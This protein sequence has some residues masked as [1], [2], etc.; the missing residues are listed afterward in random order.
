MFLKTGISIVNPYSSYHCFY[1]GTRFCETEPE[2]ITNGAENSHSV[3]L[4]KQLQRAMPFESAG[5]PTA[6]HRTKA[7][8][9]PGRLHKATLCWRLV[10]NIWEKCFP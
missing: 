8:F 4:L 10:K 1:S 7:V 5:G 9:Q 6:P 2:N 3:L